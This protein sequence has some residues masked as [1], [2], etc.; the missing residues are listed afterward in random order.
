MEKIE[1]AAGTRDI[2]G[3]KVRFLRRKGIT[4]VHVFG[5]SIESLALQCDT[6]ELKHAL[7]EAGR[8]KLIGLKTGKAKKPN[9][10][11]VREIQKNPLTGELIHV[12]FYQ[13]KMEE[14]IRV[15]LPIVTTGE[16]P[17]L[18][19]KENILV[20][21]LNILRVECLPDD[22]PSS[23]EIDITSLTET[24]DTI[25]VK[26]IALSKKIAVLSEPEQVVVKIAAQRMGE[27]EEEV[28]EA[29]TEAPE[30]AEQPEEEKEGK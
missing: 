26:D 22:I 13:V 27:V 18:K 21:A 6:A 2:L 1:L 17:A 25:R 9:N 5:H 16:A 23:V 14:K 24:D 7:T 8:T 10:V 3:K 19:L 12:D 11:V 4:P 30:I 29:A 20:H 15:D 28:V